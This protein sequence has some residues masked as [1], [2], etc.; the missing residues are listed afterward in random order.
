MN[1]DM[2][3]HDIRLLSN[4]AAKIA[5]RCALAAGPQPNSRDR[6][7]MCALLALCPPLE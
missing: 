4:R 3:C 1:L 2:Q 6:A 7:C 5:S